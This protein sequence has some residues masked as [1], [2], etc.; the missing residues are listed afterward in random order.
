MPKNRYPSLLYPHCFSFLPSFRPESSSLRIV[1]PFQPCRRNFPPFY[2][3]L[4]PFFWSSTLPPKEE[5]ERSSS[6]LP[7]KIYFQQTRQELITSPSETG[8]V[9]VRGGEGGG[10]GGARGTSLIRFVSRYDVLMALTS[11]FRKTGRIVCLRGRRRRLS[12]RYRSILP[13]TSTGQ[14]EINR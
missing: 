1:P 4:R 12:R 5:S 3:P 13:L 6:S 8:K 11:D 9:G 10:E 7:Q 2:F 14:I